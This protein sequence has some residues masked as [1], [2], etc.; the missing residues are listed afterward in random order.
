MSDGQRFQE[1]N[2]FAV[3]HG[4]FAGFPNFH[5]ADYG[6]GVVYGTILLSDTEAEWQDVPQTTYR[7]FNIHDV[8]A[9]FRAANDYAAQSGYPAAFPNF[10]QA[11]YGQGVVYGTI[12][13]KPGITEWRD[14][15]QAELGVSQIDD[16]GGMMRAAN[17]YA[18]HHGFAAGFP[19]FHQADHGQGVVCGIVL[20]NPGTTVWRDVPADLLRAYS[21]PPPPW[22]IILCHLSDRPPGPTSLQRYVDYFTKPGNGSPNAF[23]YWH[24]VSYGTGGLRGARVFGWLNLGHTTAELLAHSG[25]EQRVKAFNWGMEAVSANGIDLSAFP[26]RIVVLN[27]GGTDHG[28]AR[29]G[30]LLV[31]ADSTP[32]EPTFIF[33][34]MGH[35]F[36]IDHSFGEQATPCTGGDARPGAYCDGFDIMSAM[37][38]VAFRDDQNRISG[39]TLN[40][41]SRERLG[42]L[43]R[44][45]VWNMPEVDFSE[46]VIL[47]ALNRPAADGH[48][49]A[50]FRAPSRDPVQQVPSTYTLEFREATSWDQGFP[51]DIVVIHEVRSDG[52]VRLLTSAN[53]G[54]LQAG[55]DFAAPRSSVFVR[56]VNI[57][58]PNH[59]ATLRL[60]DAPEGSL[61]KEDSDPRVYLIQNGT[62]RWITSPRAL[63][64]LGK[65][66]ADVR[67]V[68]DGGLS[69]FPIGQSIGLLQV[70]VWPY[71]V[72]VNRPVTVTVSAVDADTGLSVAGQVIINGSVSGVT[73]VPFTRTLQSRRRKVSND[74]PEWEVTYP[75]GIVV[76]PGY[77][78]API[79]F[80]FPI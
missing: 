1:A 51:M 8:P 37:N 3:A 78:D 66:W 26:H 40:A 80:G 13:I 20:F 25:S 34:E 70:S 12:L 73:G 63:F 44:S 35:G 54:V 30:V 39:P 46:T 64:A 53:G 72:P 61:R 4:F 47:A 16:V 67:S 77:P 24:D 18:F 32:L 11:N 21:T 71:P 74:P 45:R 17:D 65:T 57:D 36:S 27:G 79:D 58:S 43:H 33:H 48:L 41:I 28:M 68:P 9:M 56:L 22:A 59:T 50:K 76:A 31:Y 69:S 23:D 75:E 7:V 2:D 14:V 10:H 5:Q 55:T 52:F 49:M 6:N 15:P 42:W 38:V 62:K 29:G 19:T 60:W